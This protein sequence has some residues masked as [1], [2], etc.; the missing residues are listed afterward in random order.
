[1]ADGLTQFSDWI[2]AQDRGTTDDEMTAAIAATVET[3]VRLGQKGKVTLE[4]QIAPA[5]KDN[6]RNVLVGTR[7][8][9]KP[10]EPGPALSIY[11][12]D[13][14]GG[15]HRDDPYAPPMVARDMA[16]GREEA[17]DF[18]VPTVPLPRDVDTDPDNTTT[19]EP[20]Q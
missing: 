11:F 7:V 19:E 17:R 12:P 15:L 9:A 20:S 6:T 3:V 2:K 10:P 16:T 4:V 8:I 14:Q 5:G 18:T 1:V 13:R